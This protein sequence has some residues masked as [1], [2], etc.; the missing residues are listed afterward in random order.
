MICRVVVAT[1]G[2]ALTMVAPA[3]A[4]KPLVLAGVSVQH[5]STTLSA[6]VSK[7]EYTN[8]VVGGD[9]YG[10]VPKH[11]SSPA[12]YVNLSYGLWGFLGSH[13]TGKVTMADGTAGP[14]TPT[15]VKNITDQFLLVFPQMEMGVAFL[16]GALHPTLGVFLGDDA[17]HKGTSLYYAFDTGVVL[18]LAYVKNMEKV[19]FVA[20][21]TVRGNYS[22]YEPQTSWGAGHGSSVDLVLGARLGKF[23][24]MSRIGAESHTLPMRGGVLDAVQGTPLQNDTTNFHLSLGFQP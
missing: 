4:E 23:T 12:G 14:D 22:F 2:L 7:V 18:G 10:F 17:V 5:Q 13:S 3:S 24:I 6:G 1:C 19:G 9:F 20:H 15:Q 16:Q 8:T 11:G 21:A